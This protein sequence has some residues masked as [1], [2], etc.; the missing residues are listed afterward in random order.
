MISLTK[1]QSTNT[2]SPPQLKAVRLNNTTGGHGFNTY[3]NKINI[4]PRALIRVLL[5]NQNFL[6]LQLQQHISNM[7]IIVNLLIYLSY[8]VCCGMWGCI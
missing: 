8:F 7:F 3:I 4:A 5:S 6:I 1:K 2:N